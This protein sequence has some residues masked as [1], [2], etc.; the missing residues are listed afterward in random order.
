MLREIRLRAFYNGEFQKEILIHRE[1]LASMMESYMEPLTGSHD[2]ID[3]WN[4]S[5]LDLMEDTLILC[6]YLHALGAKIDIIQPRIGDSFDPELHQVDEGEC[7]P[8]P[9]QSSHST[10]RWVLRPGFRCEEIGVDGH[11][12]M[13]I[14]ALVMV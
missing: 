14:E 11:R 3:S 4:F 2:N 12:S 13:I 7:E 5:S 1:R 6:F 8:D 10:V 9:L